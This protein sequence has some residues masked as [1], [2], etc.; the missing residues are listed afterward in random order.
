MNLRS[1]TWPSYLQLFLT[2]FIYDLQDGPCGTIELNSTK[3]QDNPAHLDD[4]A[5][6][7]E[8]E[9]LHT[10]TEPERRTWSLVLAVQAQCKTSSD[11]VFGAGLGS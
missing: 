8:P 9:T 3:D 5:V 4:E 11:S 10:Q 6:G 2:F 1:R 7:D